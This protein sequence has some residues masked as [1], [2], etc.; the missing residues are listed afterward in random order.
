MGGL[1]LAMG[2]GEAVFQASNG[3]AGRLQVAS[4]AHFAGQY[5]F[6]E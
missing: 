6:S 2:T 3:A 1:H 5:R 4:T